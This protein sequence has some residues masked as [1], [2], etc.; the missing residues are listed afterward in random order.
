VYGRE[1]RREQNLKRNKKCVL[2]GSGGVVSGLF[3]GDEVLKK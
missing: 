2:R 1:V 3:C